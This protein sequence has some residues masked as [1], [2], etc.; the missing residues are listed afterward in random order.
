MFAKFRMLLLLSQLLH[1]LGSA[2]QAGAVQ[3]AES[4]CTVLQWASAWYITA[5]AEPGM[6]LLSGL[7]RGAPVLHGHCGGQEAHS[8]RHHRRGHGRP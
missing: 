8:P 6:G 5:W 3:D 2:A 1:I 4:Q 7:R